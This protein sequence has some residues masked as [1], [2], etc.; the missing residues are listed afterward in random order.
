MSRLSEDPTRVLRFFAIPEVV[1]IK[2]G[3]MVT[4]RSDQHY[5]TLAGREGKGPEVID[6]SFP[7]QKET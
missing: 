5:I 2:P 7:V 6:S 1:G 3:V 4:I